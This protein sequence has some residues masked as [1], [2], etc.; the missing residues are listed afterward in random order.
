ME[1]VIKSGCG[2]VVAINKWDLVAEKT[3]A[4]YRRKL[5]DRY[6]FLRDYPVLCISGLT[7]RRGS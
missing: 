2:L 4:E 1:Q 3:A 6:P 7:G 5:R